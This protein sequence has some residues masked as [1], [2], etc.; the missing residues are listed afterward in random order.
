VPDNRGSFIEE[1]LSAGRGVVALIIGDR[2]APGHFDLSQTGMVGSFVGLLA[3]SFIGAV[4]PLF[5]PGLSENYSIGRTTVASVILFAFQLAFAVIVLRQLNRM[6]G[7]VPYLVADNWAS[8]YISAGLLVLSSFGFD[9]Q[10]A[11]F[12]LSILAIVVE[13]NIG[14][15]ILTL[16][17]LQI[18]MF[19]VAQLVGIAIALLLIGVIF[20]V[21][22]AAAAAAGAS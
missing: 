21:P 10:I 14:R 2:K 9:G 8:V 6:D 17:P 13:V 19:M 18:A 15:L 5:L 4:L 12:A 1:A 3:I 20:P 7:L 16:S 22:E 11:F